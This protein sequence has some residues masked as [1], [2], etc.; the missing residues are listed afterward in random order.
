MS[1]KWAKQ[2]LKVS[3]EKQNSFEFRVMFISDVHNWYLENR[4]LRK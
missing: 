3:K 4:K 2:S 1:Y